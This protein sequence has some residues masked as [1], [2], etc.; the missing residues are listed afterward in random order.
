MVDSMTWTT[1]DLAAHL[2]KRANQKAPAKAPAKV[3]RK[4]KVSAV[5][6]SEKDRQTAVI[7]TLTGIG[8]VVLQVA[9]KKVP[10][11]CKCG[12]RHWPKVTGNTNGVP[13]LLISHDRWVGMGVMMGMEMKTPTTRR[14]PEQIA[15]N[16]RGMTV[17]I[18]NVQ[19]A[20][21]AVYCLERQMELDPLPR[22]M[23]YMEQGGTK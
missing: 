22:F 12:L 3:A 21:Q 15:L 16:N 19:Q 8:Y 14:R 20:L 5:K 10:I 9:Q 4:P 2:A 1:D 17:I 13:D 6:I 18:E 23:A 7:T 11:V